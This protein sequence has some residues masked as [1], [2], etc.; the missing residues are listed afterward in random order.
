LRSATLTS[1]PGSPILGCGIDAPK[2]CSALN[3]V[4]EHIDYAAPR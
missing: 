2:K 3:K 4:G 1:H